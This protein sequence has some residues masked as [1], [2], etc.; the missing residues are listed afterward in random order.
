MFVARHLIADCFVDL[1]C[2]S[3]DAV[4]NDAFGKDNCLE[5]SVVASGNHEHVRAVLKDGISIAEL[6]ELM[7][8]SSPSGT[9]TPLYSVVG[10]ISCQ[11]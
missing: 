5:V 3:L 9:A 6:T 4:A 7:L 2:Q 1:V 11:S 8:T 10:S